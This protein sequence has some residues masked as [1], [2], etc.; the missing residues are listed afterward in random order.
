MS[1]NMVL[2]MGR[3]IL[4]ISTVGAT[5]TYVVNALNQ[6]GVVTGILHVDEEIAAEM[7]AAGMVGSSIV[8]DGQ[9]L[10]RGDTIYGAEVVGIERL[11]CEFEKN[12]TRWKQ[13]VREKPNPA[14]E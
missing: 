4:G 11:Y 12:G 9:V 14:W 10:N 2:L 8:V 7:E 6:Q 3:L 1:T 13:R 5:S